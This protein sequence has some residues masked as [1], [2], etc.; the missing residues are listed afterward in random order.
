MEP[1]SSTNPKIE[2]KLLAGRLLNLQDFYFQHISR[3][4]FQQVLYSYF[5]NT[6][7]TLVFIFFATVAFFFPKTTLTELKQTPLNVIAET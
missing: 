6:E 3:V 1:P 4:P 2:G 5:A 7:G